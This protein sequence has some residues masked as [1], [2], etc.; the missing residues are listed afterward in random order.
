MMVALFLVSGIGKLTAVAAT[1]GY[2]TAYGVP[3]MLVWP[4][5]AFEIGA[6]VLLLLGLW[7]RPLGLCLAGWCLLTAAIFHTAF[8][9]QNQ[10]INFLKNLTMAGGFLLLARAGATGFSLDARRALI[11]TEV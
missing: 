7:T 10:L 5:A 9:D 8:A 2:M 4:A 6:G 1:Q 3:A 11:R